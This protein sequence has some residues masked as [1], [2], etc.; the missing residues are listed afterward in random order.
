MIREGRLEA[1]D[2]LRKMALRRGQVFP[3]R[4]LSFRAET[5]PDSM[6]GKFSS[7]QL[8]DKKRNQ[9]KIACLPGGA[10]NLG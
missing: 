4:R 10:G 1:L 2:R 8:I 6:A 9:E 5:P 7:L 3:K